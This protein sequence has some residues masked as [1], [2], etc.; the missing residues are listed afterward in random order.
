VSYPFERVFIHDQYYWG[1]GAHC[2]F[3]VFVASWFG[4]ENW[5]TEY[6]ILISLRFLA[7][8]GFNYLIGY[9]KPFAMTHNFYDALCCKLCL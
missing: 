7:C 3:I 1:Y 9:P 4:G 5:E 2:P 8:I 6:D